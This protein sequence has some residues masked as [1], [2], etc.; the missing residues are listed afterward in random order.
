MK[1]FDYWVWSS[2]FAFAMFMPM[3]YLSE[4]TITTK[5][6]ILANLAVCAVLAAC[7]GWV[8]W[9]FQLYYWHQKLE[10]LNKRR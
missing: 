6:P 8:V 3:P 9:P 5:R 1:F 2:I 7:F 10:E 4:N